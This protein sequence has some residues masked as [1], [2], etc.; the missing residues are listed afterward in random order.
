M[1]RRRSHCRSG[2][3]TER[4]GQRR[5]RMDSCDKIGKS[6]SDSDGKSRLAHEIGSAFDHRV[7]ADDRLVVG[8]IG[9][10]RAVRRAPVARPLRMACLRI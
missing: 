7:Y 8:T 4:L 9:S 3:Q 6:R 10:C 1:R 5:V 2:G